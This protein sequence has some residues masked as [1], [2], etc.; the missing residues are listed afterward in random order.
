M[1]TQF[2]RGPSETKWH[3]ALAIVSKILNVFGRLEHVT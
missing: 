1:F 2:E 3:N